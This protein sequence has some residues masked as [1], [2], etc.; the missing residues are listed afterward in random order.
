LGRTIREV[1]V[2]LKDLVAEARQAATEVSPAAARQGIEEGGIVL[3]VR[4]PREF[5][6]GRIAGATNLPRGMLEL[7]AAADSPVADPELTEHPDRRVFLYCT[8][9][10]SARSLLAAQTLAMLGY[11]NVSVIEGG[12]NA[13]AEAGLPTEEGS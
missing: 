7:R 8:K 1:T 5:A 2:G 3:D 13:W 12:L 6:K 9:A 10:P 11:E 4:E